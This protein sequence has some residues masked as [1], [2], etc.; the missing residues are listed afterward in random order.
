MSLRQCVS[1]LETSS[2]AR[3]RDRDHCGAE[4]GGPLRLVALRS[5]G[6]RAGCV[7]APLAAAAG[8]RCGVG[9]CLGAGGGVEPVVS[10]GNAGSAFMMVT[11]GIDAADGKNRPLRPAAAVGGCASPS[12]PPVATAAGGLAPAG[13]AVAWRAT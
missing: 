3:V 8:R 10:G 13:H 11:G 1:L 5:I 7:L 12:P 6:G 2:V 4:A 9:A